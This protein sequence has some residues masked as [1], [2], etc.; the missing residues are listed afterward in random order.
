MSSSNTS[1]SLSDQ[2]EID[3]IVWINAFIARWLGL[4]VFIIGVVSNVLN[5][6]VLTRPALKRN[7]C[8]MYFLCSCIAALVYTAINMPLRTLQS[9]GIDPTATNLVFCKLKTFFVY[10]WR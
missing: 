3:T 1:S 7:P 2:S 10:A 6:Y 9:Y 4:A 5:M 8:C